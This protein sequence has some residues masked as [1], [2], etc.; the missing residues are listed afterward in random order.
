[1]R[2]G[3]M[4]MAAIEAKV[5]ALVDLFLLATA[6]TENDFIFLGDNFGEIDADVRCVDAPARGVSRIVRDLGAM[7]HRL[8]RRAAN[9]DARAAQVFFLDECYRP[10]QVSEAISERIAALARADDDR[11]IFH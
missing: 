1:M 7:H 3:K 4:G 2:A 6:K 9:I 11:V 10:P 5:G 8:C